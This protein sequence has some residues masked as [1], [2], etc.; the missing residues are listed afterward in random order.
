MSLIKH[1]TVYNEVMRNNNTIEDLG[2]PESEHTAEELTNY[3]ISS[4]GNLNR[5]LPKERRKYVIYLRKSTDSEDRQIRSL[6]DQKKE[7]L[8]LA[9]RMNIKIKDEDIVEE[10]ASAKKSGNRPIFDDMLQGFRIGKYHG[11]ITWSPDRLS[12]NM[13]EAGEVI[14][15]IDLE[16]IQDLQ[17]STY[18]FE[19][20]PSGKMMLGI[21]FATSKQYSDK[22]A[23]DVNRGNSGNIRDGKYNGLLKKG[24]FVE[25]G[26]SFFGV[27]KENWDLL[28]KAVVMRLHE[29]KTLEAIAEYLNQSGLSQRKRSD[30]L[31]KPVRSDKKSVQN[32]FKDSFYCGVY[33]YGDNIINLNEAH[34]FLPLM[35][36]DEHIELNKS[37]ADDFGAKTVSSSTAKRLGYGYLRG[38]VI[39]D[40]CDSV[41]KFQLTLIK[42][43]KNAGHHMITYYCENKTCKRREPGIKKSVRAKVISAAIEHTI[44]HCTIRSKEAYQ[45]YIHTIESD[46]AASKAIVKRKLSEAKDSLAQNQKMYSKYQKFQLEHPKEYD[47]HHKGNLERH[48]E[49]IEIA[50]QNVDDNKHELEKLSSS[51]PTEEEF[52]ELMDRYLL[53]VLETDDLLEKDMICSKIVANLRVREDFVSVI[54]LNPPY[55]LMADL[56]KVSLGRGE[57]TR[58]FDLTVPNRA[59]YQLRHTP[60]GVYSHDY[61]LKNRLFPV[62]Y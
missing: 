3:L 11:L 56:T 48:S 1:Y 8:D 28:R 54:T 38:K 15:M 41:M 47:K 21:L 32:L 16:L 14:E 17:F 39:C 22:L 50:R 45:M 37:I 61:T 52:S 6:D 51:L 4:R 24:Y 7:C 12:R 58:T 26:T 46:I 19:N 31:G 36:V 2:L 35:T 62:V 60:T 33:K 9:K 23:V 42:R 25:H 29:K 57:R 5:I 18:Q 40:Y 43:G 59:R 10:S 34:N 13:K 49:L 20:T 30:D 53:T 27:D 55:D 44:R